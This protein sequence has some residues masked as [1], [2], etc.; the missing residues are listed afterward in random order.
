MGNNFRILNAQVVNDLICNI[1][2]LLDPTLVQKFINN[3]IRKVKIFGLFL[4]VILRFLQL[5]FR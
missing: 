4:E 3:W 5:I 2:D 1:S